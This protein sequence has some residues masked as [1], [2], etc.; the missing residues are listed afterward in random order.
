VILLYDGAVCADG[1][2]DR[3]L[4]DRELLEAHRLELPLRY[5]NI[6]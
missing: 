4:R 3:I 1:P 6:R 5:A 2:A